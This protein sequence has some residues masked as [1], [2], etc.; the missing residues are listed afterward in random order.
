MANAPWK[1][2]PTLGVKQIASR[3]YLVLNGIRHDTDNI[4]PP[5]KGPV[6]VQIW[7]FIG[8]TFVLRC[9][10]PF[11]VAPKKGSFLFDMLDPLTGPP[12]VKE[13]PYA[14]LAITDDYETHVPVGFWD[15]QGVGYGSDTLQHVFQA[16]ANQAYDTPIT[17]T[18]PQSGK[19]AAYTGGVLWPTMTGNAIPA[20]LFFEHIA[21]LPFNQKAARTTF[22][23]LMQMATR[24]MGEVNDARMQQALASLKGADANGRI[25]FHAR[26]LRLLPIMVGH[27]DEQHEMWQLPSL[28][29][30]PWLTQADCEDNAAWVLT[31]AMQH[32]ALFSDLEDYT[33][34]VFQVCV[35]QSGSADGYHTV[36][37]LINN[38]TLETVIRKGDDKEEK[39]QKSETAQVV[40]LDAA[41]N[42]HPIVG[43]APDPL[44]FEAYNRSSPMFTEEPRSASALGLE[45]EHQR[46]AWGDIVLMIVPSGPHK[47][48]YSPT[49]RGF[50]MLA[51]KKP[52]Q[53]GWFTII[54]NST[55]KQ[56]AAVAVSFAAITKVYSPWTDNAQ[57]L[58]KV[59]AVAFKFTPA[60]ADFRSLTVRQ[61]EKRGHIQLSDGLVLVFS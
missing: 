11:P 54:N 10:F 41:A 52:A 14:T 23:W 29:P 33:P 55:A 60:V 12:W 51:F 22:N 1:L 24:Q 43:D 37:A 46:K 6:L 34:V 2:V 15:G 57:L 39:K 21:Q 47:G 8:K 13:T 5:P 25:L 48:E 20:F 32:K 31:L 35:A 49:T 56:R 18:F 9:S 50:N 38:D 44:W 16:Y 19:K 27:N 3:V 40:V 42:V 30:F 28:S 4:R 26:V 45:E 59:P 61:T 36:T 58:P 17:T 53:A 7:Q